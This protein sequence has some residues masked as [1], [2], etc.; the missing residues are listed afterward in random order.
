MSSAGPI[1]VIVT[2]YN[3]RQY[4]PY[5]LRSLEA[6]T[7]PRDRFEVIVVKN[8]EDK[9]SDEI[10]RRNGWKEVY[11]DEQWQGRFLLA[12]LEEA[13]GDIIT[14]LED[15]D[16][17]REVRLEKVYR[18]LGSHAMFYNL[19]QPID[20][21][22]R[23]IGVRLRPREPPREL[24]VSDAREVVLYNLDFNASSM[25]VQRRVAERARLDLVRKSVDTALAAAAL[26][27]GS[28]RVV[29]ERLTLYR[30]HSENTS[31]TR[32]LTAEALARKYMEYYRDYMAL[33]E[34][35][36]SK[37][38]RELLDFRATYF[39]SILCLGRGIEGV[40]VKVRP[41]KAVWLRLRGW[42]VNRGAVLGSIL[43][44][45]PAD[46]VRALRLRRFLLPAGEEPGGSA[47]KAAK[48]LFVAPSPR[49][50]V[51]QRRW[52]ALNASVPGPSL[53]QPIKDRGGLQG[54]PWVPGPLCRQ[55]GL[56]GAQR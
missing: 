50:R 53:G 31:A 26:E 27:A 55:R 4:L 17:Y 49:R 45:V 35:T 56:P 23:E 28:I 38:S 47:V 7:L 2:A 9:E 21:N 40:E 11:S 20:A 6:Q 5:A 13:K 34:A 48:V 42:P 24:E 43:C 14:F 52:A 46:L 30:V 37:V 36:T 8:F 18:G 44:L 32:G 41:L 54:R 22:G 51:H 1:S 10:I 29:P 3:R 12:G 19:Q 16:M 15:D 25:A 33:R 39:G